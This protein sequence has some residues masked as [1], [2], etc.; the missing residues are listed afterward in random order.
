MKNLNLVLFF[1]PQI[2]AIAIPAP[3][4]PEDGL[5]ASG[6]WNALR[7]ENDIEKRQ[8]IQVYEAGA[9]WII[10]RIRAA[11]EGTPSQT[12]GPDAP[13][14]S[15]APAATYDY[16]LHGRTT[17]LSKWAHTVNE[18]LIAMDIKAP[19]GEAQIEEFLKEHLDISPPQWEAFPVPE[20]CAACF[21]GKANEIHGI[22]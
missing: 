18:D 19:G 17:P 13:T 10:G 1:V 15:V 7:A 16:E 20:P 14:T 9:A 5:A 3:I 8:M 21:K 22:P 11:V 12:P 4:I 6:A 2:L